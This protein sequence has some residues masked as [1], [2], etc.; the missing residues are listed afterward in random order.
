MPGRYDNNLCPRCW[1]FPET[2]THKYVRCSWVSGAWETVRDILEEL[3]PDIEDR[4]NKDILHLNFRR[5]DRENDM[6]WLIGS[7]L[8]YVEDFVVVRN[9][10]VVVRNNKIY[11]AGV[12]GY[13]KFKKLNSTFLAMPE[14]G[15]MPL[16]G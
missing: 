15:E 16:I 5:T 7:Y 11:S 13:L 14:L 2:Q 8:E 10:F 3:D 9:N 4:T 1:E 12:V 6:M